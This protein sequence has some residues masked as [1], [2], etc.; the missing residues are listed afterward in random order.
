VWKDGRR[1]IFLALVAGCEFEFDADVGAENGADH[2]VA[3]ISNRK[4]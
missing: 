3:A 2:G 4:S 1:E